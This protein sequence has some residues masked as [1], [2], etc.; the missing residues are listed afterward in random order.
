MDQWVEEVISACGA[1][2]KLIEPAWDRVQELGYKAADCRINTCE[3]SGDGLHP[4]CMHQFWCAGVLVC[5][6][7]T[8][9][10]RTSDLSW[11]VS[12]VDRYIAWP[13]VK[14]YD[15]VMRARMREDEFSDW[16]RVI[17][18]P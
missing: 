16:R 1:W 17:D 15:G 6:V 12:H 5:E 14:N 7:I 2:S 4:D 3:W 10:K 13:P 9:W 11:T 18:A 8:T